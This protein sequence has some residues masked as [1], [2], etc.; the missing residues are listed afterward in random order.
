MVSAIVKF[1]IVVSTQHALKFYH[2]HMA[3]HGS[4]CGSLLHMKL[5]S[6]RNL[7]LPYSIQFYIGAV[8]HWSVFCQT[9]DPC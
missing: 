8:F 6:A 7:Y 4:C 1:C 9:A 5:T 3:W 2:S